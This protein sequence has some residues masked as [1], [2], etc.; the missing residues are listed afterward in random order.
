MA[1]GRAVVATDVGDTRYL[2]DH[3][4]TGFVVRPGDTDE[5]VTRMRALIEDP[6]LCKQFGEAGRKKA[7]AEFG[8]D[9]LVDNTLAAYRE[10]GW[11]D[12]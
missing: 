6:V 11:M 10:F 2:I 9:R 8:A 5:L 12:T 3:E 1:A 4:K 7:E